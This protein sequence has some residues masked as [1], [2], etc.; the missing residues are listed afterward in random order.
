MDKVRAEDMAFQTCRPDVFQSPW[1]R[2][3]QVD[4][5]LILRD[6][7]LVSIPVDKV[8]ASLNEAG[9][10]LVRALEVSIPVDKVR[11]PDG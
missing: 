2:F 4:F 11:A 5:D 6:E 8:R 7:K 1:I 10:E 9:E 3:A